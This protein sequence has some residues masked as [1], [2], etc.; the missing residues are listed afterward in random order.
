[1]T[2]SED[3]FVVVVSACGGAAHAL[4]PDLGWIPKDCGIL[5]MAGLSGFF[6]SMGVYVWKLVEKRLEK[7][8]M[9]PRLHSHAP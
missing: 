5:I 3:I 9:R 7:R 2:R 1:M 8:K 4:V 6:G